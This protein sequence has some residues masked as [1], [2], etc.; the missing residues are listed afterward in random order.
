MYEA[1]LFENADSQLD[2]SV[3]IAE[4]EPVAENG[5]VDEDADATLHWS[6]SVEAY[7]LQT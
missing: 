7:A 1:A 3:F 4:E 5:N 6:T 2:Q